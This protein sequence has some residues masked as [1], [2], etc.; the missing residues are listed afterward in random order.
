MI[1]V[2]AMR[3]YCTYFDRNYLYKG[4]AL[5]RSLH[6]HSTQFT[7]WILCFDE[8]TYNILD[9][10]KLREVKLISLS[11]FEQHNLE[12][13][14][15]KRTRN[16]VEYY[17]TCTPSLPYYILRH[18]PEIDIITYFDADLYFYQDLHPLYTELGQ[19]SILIVGHR[20][21]PDHIAAQS[22]RGIFNVSILSFR[23]NSDGLTCLR[24]WRDRC[25]EWCFNRVEEGRFGDQKYLDD[26]P[27]R[28]PNTH[29]LQHKGIGLAPWNI[30]SYDVR[31]SNG[32]IY[33]DGQELIVYHFHSL[34]IINRSI[35]DL[36]SQSYRI[37]KD[38]VHMLYRPY[39]RELQQAMCDVH[40]IARDFNFGY[41]YL[42]WYSK[43]GG[44]LAG[45]LTFIG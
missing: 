17:W 39:L 8:E 37:T 9:R 44:L 31:M 14:E 28:F 7:L 18:H 26:W 22:R 16:Q 15:V 32:K 5:Y 43:V 29:V 41:T 6:R 24:W 21:S 4:L 45:R 13:L 20:Y 12:L 35:Y 11:E 38:H 42:R 40:C 36:A 27:V 10:M 3:Y 30:S 23:N 34:R 33:V 19:K 2:F 25:L 1:M